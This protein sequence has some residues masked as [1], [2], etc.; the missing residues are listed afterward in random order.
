MPDYPEYT[1]PN[2]R[3]AFMAMLLQKLFGARPRMND[4]EAAMSGPRS[5]TLPTAILKGY[6]DAGVGKPRGQAGVPDFAADA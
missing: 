1:A 6:Q 5:Q 3:T 4:A 2:P